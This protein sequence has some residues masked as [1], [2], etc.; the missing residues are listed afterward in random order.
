MGITPYTY[1]QQYAKMHTHNAAVIYVLVAANCDKTCTKIS[2][3]T[4]SH[5]VSTTLAP[6][7]FNPVAIRQSCFPPA[8]KRGTRM[9]WR[10]L[11]ARGWSERAVQYWA[12]NPAGEIPPQNLRQVRCL[13][14]STTG[15]FIC[16]AI[17]S[18]SFTLSHPSHS[19]PIKC[20]PFPN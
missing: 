1:L 6:G 3:G 14:C 2:T 7:I 10:V 11:A 8:R 17:E 15:L 4:A 12:T 16:F 13:H 19:W 20:L 9:T 5:N 18:Y